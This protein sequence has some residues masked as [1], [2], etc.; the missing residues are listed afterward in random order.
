MV[1]RSFSH[2]SP[3][4]PSLLPRPFCIPTCIFYLMLLSYAVEVMHIHAVS[5]VGREGGKGEKSVNTPASPA[6]VIGEKYLQGVRGRTNS[7][8]D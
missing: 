1:G 8:Y 5:D 4:S 3:A 7:S 6:Y 2:L